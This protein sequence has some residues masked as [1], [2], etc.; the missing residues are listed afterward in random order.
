MEYITEE[1]AKIIAEPQ[2]IVD[3]NMP[4]F[5]N[6]LMKLNRDL[7]IQIIKQIKKEELNI[8]LPLAG[9]GIRG[10]R[11]EQEI[12]E[13]KLKIYVNDKK[14][15]FN[16]Y[17][18]KINK[19]NNTNLIPSNLD[20]NIFLHSQ[21]F[22]YIDIDPFGTP[23]PFL[24]SAIQN[25]KNEGILA[26]TAT[27]TGA[28]SGSF[29]NACQRKYQATPKRDEFMHITGI[30]ILIR[31]I[32]LI[33]I[34]HSIALT[35]IYSISQL[36]YMKIFFKAK[37]GKKICDELLKSHKKINETGPLYTGNLWD[38]DTTK[39]ISQALKNQKICQTILEEAK[40]TGE[41]IDIHK[42]AKKYK[43]QQIPKLEDLKKKGIIFSRSHFSD[44]LI[45]TDK[46]EEE[47]I[48]I[49]QQLF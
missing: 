44:T 2:K 36:H 13:K 38:I 37:K 4:I 39:K 5:Y 3:K 23:I 48:K 35:P 41:Y 22:D 43:L 19:I 11:I 32:Q 17:I 40:Q 24:D 12:P 26:V 14:F 9:S 21:K 28:L 20:A 45:K 1:S 47:I 29:V 15:E 18:Q 30:R 42:L 8:G 27:D 46:K 10:I 6:P 33:G 16:K 25:I 34:Q 49:I 31:K 7:S